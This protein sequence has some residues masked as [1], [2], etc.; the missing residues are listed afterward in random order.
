MKQGFLLLAAILLL[1]LSVMVVASSSTNPVVIVQPTSISILNPEIQKQINER[2][3]EYKN[4]ITQANNRIQE[5]TDQLNNP[6]PVVETTV[7]Y[8]A[9]TAENAFQIAVKAVG[10]DETLQDIPELVDYQGKIVYIVTLKDGLVYVDTES[11][12]I[13]Y[14]GVRKTINEQE[15]AEIVGK[16]LGG[17]NPKYSTVKKVIL[18]GTEIYKV[19]FNVYTVYIDRFGKVVKA[20][21]FE[22]TSSGSGGGEGTSVSSSSSVPTKVSDERDGDGEGD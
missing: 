14:N 16:F 12:E 13:L 22:Y 8:P 17:M 20:Q 4:L 6:Q 10:T 11:G 7:R 2:E 21:K 15:A 5:L 19:V 1:V 3:A 9:I 18:N